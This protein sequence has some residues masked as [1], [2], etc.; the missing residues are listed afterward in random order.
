MSLCVEKDDKKGVGKNYLLNRKTFLITLKKKEKRNSGSQ[1]KSDDLS[2]CLP[3]RIALML[4]T[5]F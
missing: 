5:Y 1:L 2:D 4:A 3:K